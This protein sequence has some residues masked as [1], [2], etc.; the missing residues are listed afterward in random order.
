MVKLK[1]AIDY[2]E[3]FIQ[4]IFKIIMINTKKRN[5]LKSMAMLS[6]TAFL[7]SCSDKTNFKK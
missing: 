2:I 3:D 4:Y 7:A 5:L 6:T 1:L